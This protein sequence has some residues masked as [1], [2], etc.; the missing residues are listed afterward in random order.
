M[1][2]TLAIYEG[3]AGFRGMGTYDPGQFHFSP[4]QARQLLQ[5]SQGGGRTSATYATGGRTPSDVPLETPP[6]PRSSDGLSTG[7]MV[8]LGVGAVALLAL[9]YMILR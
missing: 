8:G 7:E 2:D 4:A 9:G 1:N 5:L 3:A 6:L